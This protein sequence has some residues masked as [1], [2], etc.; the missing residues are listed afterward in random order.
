MPADQ[1]R[2]E[3]YFVK[4]SDEVPVEERGS[5]EVVTQDRNNLKHSAPPEGAGNTAAL[6]GESSEGQK[7]KPNSTVKISVMDDSSTALSSSDGSG[8]PP[9]IDGKSVASGT[10][11]ALDEKE[12]LR[13]DDSASLRA[14][15]EEDIVT[16]SDNMDSRQGSENGLNRAFREQL[17]EIT[18]MIPQ[19]GRG[20]PPGR[21]P[22]HIT[23]AQA[24]YDPNQSLNTARRV[25][26]PLGNGGPSNA[27]FLP[28]A[29]LLE[30]L[31]SPRDRL[32]ITKLEH[33]FGDLINSET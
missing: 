11:F 13:P 28:D 25:S 14:V 29:K 21:F 10:T 22:N 9:S 8:K 24:L 12:S 32:F 1:D 26:Q 18:E 5:P 17:N 15:E 30:A 3:V 6:S 19:A 20:A 4:T 31:M 33:D 23:G 16:P 2:D 27:P 7:L